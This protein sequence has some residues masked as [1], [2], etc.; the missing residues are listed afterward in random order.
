MNLILILIHIPCV[1]GVPG[2]ICFQC[3]YPA[4]EGKDNKKQYPV[5]FNAIDVSN[6]FQW[7][8]MCS[9]EFQ[10]VKVFFSTFIDKMKKWLPTNLQE[11]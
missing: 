1:Q 5:V 3:I 8:N 6:E 4:E 9:N 11:N 10:W 2:E 7:V